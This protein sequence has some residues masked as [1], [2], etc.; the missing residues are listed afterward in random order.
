MPWH[1]TFSNESSYSQHGSEGGE[2]NRIGINSY[3]YT[4]SKYQ[5]QSCFTKLLGMFMKN[6]EPDVEF[7]APIPYDKKI[8][9]N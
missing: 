4:P 3:S 6:I 8:F 5:I 2:W 1:P 7:K 9:Y